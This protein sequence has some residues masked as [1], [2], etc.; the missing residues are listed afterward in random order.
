MNIK[1]TFGNYHKST[2][3][4]GM[5][6]GL[7]VGAS[8]VQADD[9]EIYLQEPPD[10]V[11][12]NVLFILDESGSMSGDRMTNLKAAMKTLLGDALMDNVNAGILGYTTTGGQN[13]DKRLTRISDFK[14][15]KDN[16]AAMIDAVDGLSA[17]NWT[18]T[19]RA[20]DAGVKWFQGKE[21][22][23]EVTW[24]SPIGD[25][26]A[27][28]YCAPNHM[29]ILSDGTPNSNRDGDQDTLR[30]YPE[31][32]GLACTRVDVGTNFGGTCATEISAWAFNTDLKTG[33]GWTGEQNIVTHAI[34]FDAD[35]ATEDFMISIANASGNGV[36]EPEGQHHEADDAADLLVAFASIVGQATTAIDY[37]YS[38]PAIPFN[39]DN[40]ALSGDYLYV[41]MFEPAP[42]KFWKGNLKK[43]K[44]TTVTTT[45]SE[46]EEVVTLNIKDK[47][48]GKVLDEVY[49]FV[50]STDLWSTTS[51][52]AEPLVGGAAQHMTGTRNLYTYL[53]PGDLAV[54]GDESKN[55]IDPVNRVRNANANITQAMLNVTTD[56]KR[57]KVLDWVSWQD[58]GNAHEGEMGAPI[59]SQPVVVSYSSLSGGDLVL[60]PTSEG[61]LE[62]FDAKTGQEV[63]GFIPEI[64]LKKLKKLRNNPD[65]TKPL[66]GLDGPITTYESGGKKYVVVGMR[67]GG[68]DYYALDISTRNA[69]KFAWSIKNTDSDFLDLAQTWSKPLFVRMDIG[70]AYNAD[71]DGDGTNDSTDVLVFGGGYDKDQDDA[72]SRVADD[73]G[74]A[75]YIVNP[76]TGALIKDISNSEADLNISDMTN[77]IAGDLL[78]VD[79]NANGIIDRLYAA[80]VG[81]RIIR[82][83]IP[84]SDFVDTTLSGG[85]VADINSGVSDGFRRFFNTPEVGYFNKG[86][87]QY[88][89]ILIGSGFRPEPIDSTV[90]DRFY[91]IKDPG[92]WRAPGVDSDFDGDID[93]FS[94]VAVTTDDLYDAS[95]NL[96][97]NGL[98]ETIRDDAEYD[99][100]SSNGW[101][102]DFDGGEKSFSKARLYNYVVMFT[103]YLGEASDNTDLCAV[104][105]TPG[106]A[107]FYAV[108]MESAAAVFSDF[109]GDPL[110]LNISD[111]FKKISIPGIPPAPM[112]IYP[113][114][115][116]DGGL[117]GVVKAIVGLEEV[118]QWPDRFHAVYWEE[119]IE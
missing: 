119:V 78:T 2:L 50:D 87:V 12:P 102:I 98:T 32:D 48:D 5:V 117:G 110:D 106:E 91:M 88:L 118:A 104:S 94:Y 73:E 99:L 55:L 83:D 21:Q 7:T 93:S 60:L 79:I 82:V 97:Q 108:H 70:V 67:R 51:D 109:D 4:L 80:D 76:R 89:A 113:D 103:T 1:R 43:Y 64:L 54:A 30:N 101:Y 18:P 39:P 6:L 65:S 105:S 28:N 3:S 41:P 92:V 58:S 69:P 115:E 44:L 45:D 37:A 63:W 20:L 112:L 86:G 72:T 38:S 49:H 85:I 10:P 107:R 24:E 81:G 46:G 9:I 17:D 111:R 71:A 53:A 74:N 11:P 90:T 68:K 42:N 23:N 31:P 22:I 100:D 96:F 29:V 14:K 66:Y 116:D 56:G 59:H 16:R 8:A 114:Y 40:A 61:V 77:G 52:D 47:G 35:G 25:T 13:T 34:S 15:V 84:D 57:T 62:A 95:D 19:V 33:D 27:D 75:I 26:A 36:D